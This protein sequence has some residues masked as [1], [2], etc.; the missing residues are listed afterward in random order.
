MLALLGEFSIG[1]GGA[2]AA[3]ADGGRDGRG[4]EDGDE[5]GGEGDEAHEA[6]DARN[7]NEFAG[8][9]A[10][11]VSNV[12]LLRTWNALSAEKKALG[13]SALPPLSPDTGRY[14]SAAEDA[15]AGAG[16]A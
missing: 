1:A 2:A 12:V 7:G 5:H 3:G 11:V 15:A 13:L 10:P 4:E 16:A 14:A 6:R 8:R 9:V